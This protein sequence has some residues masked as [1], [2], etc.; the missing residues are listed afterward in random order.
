MD[1]GIITGVESELS[2]RRAIPFGT[3]KLLTSTHLFLPHLLRFHLA[4]GQI[5]AAV[6]FAAHFTE[7]SYFA[8]ALEILLHGVLEQEADEGPAPSPLVVDGIEWT[9]PL[10]DLSPMTPTFTTDVGLPSTSDALNEDD[11]PRSAVDKRPPAPTEH[12]RGVGVLPLVVEFLDHFPEALAVVVGCARKTELSRWDFLF[13]VVGNP[14]DLFEVR[15]AG[16][17]LPGSSTDATDAFPFAHQAC[18]QSGRLKTATS[19][20]LVL[21][22]LERLSSPSTDTLRVLRRAIDAGEWDLCKDLLR[23]LHSVDGDGR[24]LTA[25]VRELGVFGQADL[26]HL[27]MGTTADDSPF[28]EDEDPPAATSAEPSERSQTS[29]SSSPSPARPAA[30]TTTGKASQQPLSPIVDSPRPAISSSTTSSASLTGLSSLLFGASLGSPPPP[31]TTPTG[32]RVFSRP[33]GPAEQPSPSP[34][35]AR[36]SSKPREGGGRWI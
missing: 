11:E 5:R 4:R 10:S 26:A 31:T 17:P 25:V 2:V 3:F 35:P 29:P 7:L 9:R 36:P 24:E 33:V 14:R 28:V 19:Y 22:T 34:S 12:W 23:F 16:A 21:H 18:L 6:G 27:V 13:D 32:G 1:K 8:H 15:L 20:L 30:M